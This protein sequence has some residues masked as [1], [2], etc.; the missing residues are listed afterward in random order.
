MECIVGDRTVIHCQMEGYNAVTT[1]TVRQCVSEDT[2][3]G[4][5]C[6]VPKDTVA[7][8][9]VYNRVTQH[10]NCE[11]DRG[12]M[13]T[14]VLI[15]EME[16]VRDQRVVSEGVGRREEKRRVPDGCH[17]RSLYRYRGHVCGRIRCRRPPEKIIIAGT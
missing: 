15:L 11:I 9:S 4:I 14:A 5:D 1:S 3:L 2:R 7:N 16:R 12:V 17:P 10:I 6:P 8:G 13:A